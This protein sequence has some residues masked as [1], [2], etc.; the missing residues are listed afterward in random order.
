[1]RFSTRLCFSVLSSGL[2]A[3]AL[4][5]TGVQADDLTVVVHRGDD[6]TEL[7]FAA[8]ALTLFNVFDV[9]PSALTG[10]SD[11]VDFGELRTGTAWLGDRLVLDTDIS[12]GKNPVLFEAMSFMVHP[13]EAKLPITS[14]YEAMVA[15]GVCNGP[16]AG[17]YV[18]ISDLY[19]Y[20]GYFVDQSSADGAIEIDFPT[21]QQDPLSIKIYDYG[22]AGEINRNHIILDAGDALRIPAPRMPTPNRALT[23]F[24]G[25]VIMF[26]VAMVPLTI[27]RRLNGTSNRSPV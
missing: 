2:T 12:F 14:P 25:G 8:D 13:V 22:T 9:A 18:S 3:T 7:Y 19:S 6:W 20:V 5:T 11:K 26:G 1:M 24:L 4:L 21:S 16:E 23:F 17:T 15:I 10:D 27:N